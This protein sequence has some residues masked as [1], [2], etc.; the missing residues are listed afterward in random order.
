MKRRYMLTAGVGALGAI[1]LSRKIGGASKQTV[2]AT[3][4]RDSLGTDIEQA[5]EITKTERE[6]RRALT[7]EQFRILREHGTE[8]AGSSPLDK[9][10]RS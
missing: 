4:P 2:L 9:E 7:P 5:F 3:S 6:W 10:Y 1:A 8:W